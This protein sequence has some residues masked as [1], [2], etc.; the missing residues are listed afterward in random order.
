LESAVDREIAVL[1]KYEAKQI[2]LLNLL[3]DKKA[4]KELMSVCGKLPGLKQQVES[5]L[6][7]DRLLE[8]LVT[9]DVEIEKL[10]KRK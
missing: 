3:K 2:E 4:N 6:G 5:V 7:R 1:K 10:E 9:L 8:L